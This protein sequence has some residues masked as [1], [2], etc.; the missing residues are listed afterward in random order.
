MTSRCAVI[1]RC[2]GIRTA[3]RSQRKPPTTFLL[4]PGSEL[5]RVAMSEFRLTKRARADLIDIY[6]FTERKFG[7][8]QAEA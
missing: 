8:Y 1:K 3:T 6:E 2:S 5:P 7:A 4:P